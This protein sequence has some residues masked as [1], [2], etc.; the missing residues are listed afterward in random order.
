VHRGGYCCCGRG[1]CIRLV[2]PPECSV[3]TVEPGGIVGDAH[4]VPRR[5]VICMCRTGKQSGDHSQ[6]SPVTHATHTFKTL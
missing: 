5:L 4:T 3:V 2:D 1:C 6:E